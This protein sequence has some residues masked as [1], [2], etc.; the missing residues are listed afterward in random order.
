MAK[1]VRFYTKINELF[2]K[3][4]NYSEKCTSAKKGVHFYNDMNLF[5]AACPCLNC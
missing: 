5:L 3:K 4:Y 2:L 1:F